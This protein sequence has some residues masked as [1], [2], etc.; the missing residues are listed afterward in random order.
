MAIP[1]ALCYCSQHHS[2]LVTT[3]VVVE[4]LGANHLTVA[5]AVR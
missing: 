5:A 3:E 4:A 1:Y 2:K